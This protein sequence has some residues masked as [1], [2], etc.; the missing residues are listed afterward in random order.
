MIK[1]TP[2][3]TLSLTRHSQRCVQKLSVTVDGH[4]TRSKMEL[5]SEIYSIYKIEMLLSYV[6]LF[7]IIARPDGPPTHATCLAI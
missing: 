7:S 3:P 6:P 4:A 2:T 1:P 5:K